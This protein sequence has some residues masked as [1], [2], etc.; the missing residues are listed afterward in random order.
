VLEIGS[1][2]GIGINAHAS[3]AHP[4]AALRPQNATIVLPSNRGSPHDAHKK[5]SDARYRRGLR[6]PAHGCP[7]AAE[8]RRRADAV[9]PNPSKEWTEALPVGN[10]VLGAT[11]L[12]PSSHERLHSNLNQG[13][14]LVGD[15]VLMGKP[16]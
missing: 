15:H 1:P 6:A 11:V 3:R 12:G 7:A 14:F 9:V 13:E 2:R 8:S 10:G 4:R 16:W 5:R